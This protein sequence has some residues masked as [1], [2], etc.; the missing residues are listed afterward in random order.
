MFKVIRRILATVAVTLL[1]LKA[2]SSFLSWVENQED[3][4]ADTWVDEDELEDA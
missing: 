4:V 1:A 3:S 2:V